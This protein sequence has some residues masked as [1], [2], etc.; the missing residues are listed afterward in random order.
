MIQMFKVR[1]SKSASK[2]V[3]KVLDSGFVGQGPKVEEFD[4]QV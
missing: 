1:M 2:D 4:V 3:K